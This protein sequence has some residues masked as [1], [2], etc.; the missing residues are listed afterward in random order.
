MRDDPSEPRWLSRRAA[1][2]MHAQ[3]IREHGGRH[4]VRDDG[5][6]DSALARPHNRWAHGDDDDLAALAAT[7]GYGLA[8]NHGYVD[9]NKRIAF[10]ALFVFLH[11]NGLLLAA[12]EPDAVVI[13]TE[14]A[15]GECTERHLA[16][17]IRRHTT[18]IA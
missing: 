9:G 12:P 11:M 14:V 6:I 4:G 1:D 5:L 7:L 17:W 16:D 2:A 8:K 10:M 15:A 18:P 13:M 3:L